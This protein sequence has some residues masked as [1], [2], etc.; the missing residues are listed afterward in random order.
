MVKQLLMIP[1]PFEQPCDTLTNGNTGAP[2]ELASRFSD[3]THVDGL[4][5]GPPVPI[6]N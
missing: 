2:A 1:N 6:T 5:A 3:I 4:I